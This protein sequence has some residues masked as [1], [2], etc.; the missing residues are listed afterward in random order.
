MWVQSSSKVVVKEKLQDTYC[1]WVS[2]LPLATLC[3]SC[4][5]NG[6]PL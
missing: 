4:V 6:T 1:C 5:C 3:V 2:A